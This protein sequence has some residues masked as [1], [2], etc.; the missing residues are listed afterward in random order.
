MTPQLQREAGGGA[1][2]VVGVLDTGLRIHP[3]GVDPARLVA[4][5][6]CNVLD[7]N[8][9]P[10]D[11]LLTTADWLDRDLMGAPGHGTG[12]AA[13]V[14]AG[15]DVALTPYSA[16]WWERSPMIGTAPEATIAPFRVMRGP[17][18]LLD[19]DVAV[20]VRRASEHCH[21]LSM[22]L[23]GLAFR[24]LRQAID[25][26][27]ASG[28][29]VVCAAGNEFGVVIEPASYRNTIAVAST[30]LDG[31]PYE[32]GSSRGPEV[33]IAAPGVDILKPDWEHDDDGGEPKA[34]S[35]L[36][37]GTSYATAHVAGVAALWLS[38]HGRD[39]L[40]LAYPGERLSEV[41][42]YLLATT[43]TPW[44]DAD[45]TADWGPGPVDVAAL[46]AAPVFDDERGPLI[47]A[48]VLDHV[49][50]RKAAVAVTSRFA[51]GLA[52]VLA[53]DGAARDQGQPRRR[54]VRPVEPHAWRPR[55]GR[56]RAGARGLPPAVGGPV[57]GRAPR[58]RRRQPRLPPGA[59]L[60]G[61]RGPGPGRR[62]AGAAAGVGGEQPLRR[63]RRCRRT[64][65][66]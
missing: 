59:G 38:H 34:T 58:P 50:D 36:G 35:S 17:V 65:R 51:G 44:A 10:E 23:G 27:V 22:S 20:G 14:G 15:G 49:F 13:C 53:A 40:C 1:G 8:D 57:A 29:I 32:A 9:N 54:A 33:T 61:R 42:A 26:A 45:L 63:H 6:G 48:R 52:S 30:N 41:F 19:E 60:D 31:T 46:L 66:G 39:E 55:G 62:H 4:F 21:V 24:D 12:T 43:A 5:P 47:E 25:D 64:S 28:I 3:D 2:I 11:P 56:A 18:H 7:G 37:I 16:D